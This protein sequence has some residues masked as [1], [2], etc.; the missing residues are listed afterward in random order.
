[1]KTFKLCTVESTLEAAAFSALGAAKLLPADSWTNGVDD[2]QMVAFYSNDQAACQAIND[3]TPDCGYFA[4]RLSPSRSLDLDGWWITAP[5]MT[6][7]DH[8]KFSEY[9]ESY[10]IDNAQFITECW[11]TDWSARQ[12]LLYYSRGAE[13][14]VDIGETGWISPLTWEQSRVFLRVANKYLHD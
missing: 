2:G 8:I 9:V 7:T 4:A 14:A 1:M 11:G 13:A 6:A 3:R 10:I 12:A 5:L